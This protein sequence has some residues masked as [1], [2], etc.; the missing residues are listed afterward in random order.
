MNFGSEVYADYVTALRAQLPADR[1]VSTGLDH[2][3]AISFLDDATRGWRE[4]T[5]CPPSFV[6]AF[7]DRLHAKLS[8]HRQRRFTAAGLTASDSVGP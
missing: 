8:H 2:N 1:S 3:R 7:V 4:W 5:D 6:E